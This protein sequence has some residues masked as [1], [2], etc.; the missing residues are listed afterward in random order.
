MKLNSV[1][2][3]GLTARAIASPVS[4]FQIHGR[5]SP[6]GGHIKGR[7]VARSAV[8]SASIALK[9]KNVKEAEDLVLEISDPDSP[10]YGQHL[11]SEEIVDLFAPDKEDID[12]VKAWLVA[13]GVSAGS[14]QLS[15]S[16]GWM[17]F[18]TT[19]GQL[20][21]MLHTQYHQYSARD[22]STIAIGADTYSL[23][24]DISPLVEF[25]HPATNLAG[26][27]RRNK[28]TK[29]KAL[30]PFTDSIDPDSLTTCDVHVTPKCIAAMY[31]IPKAR[32]AQ[33]GNELAIFSEADDKYAQE[34][35]DQ[36]FASMNTGIPKGTGPI[37][38]NI[39]GGHAPAAPG[40]AGDE[41]SIDFEVAIPIIYPQK[42]SLF[43]MG[44]D[45]PGDTY[46]QFL[47]LFSGS[48]CQRNNGTGEMAG[49]A[50]PCEKF[51]R[52]NVLSVSWG[53]IETPEP[54]QV[55]LN[56]RQCTEWMKFALAG[57]TVFSASGDDGV[58]Q[59]R[60]WGP[61]MDIFGNDQLSAC[62]YITAVGSTYLPKGAKIGDPEVATTSFSSGG[63]FS[64]VY[65]RPA[66]QEKAVATYL[67]HYVPN[68]RSFNTTDGK[69]PTAPGQG[70]YNR[71]GR[72]YPDISAVGDNG[73]IIQNGKTVVGGGTSMSAPIVASMFNRI[74]EE[75]ISMGKKPLGFIN[76]ALYKAQ[77]EGVFTDVVVGDQGQHAQA[78]G[79]HKGFVASKGWDPVTGLGTPRYGP[80]LEYFKNL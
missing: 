24:E 2:A 75:R 41:S 59:H 40:T 71:G 58:D 47:Q 19:A 50:P 25:L 11:T 46:D 18:N 77:S 6:A 13:S 42:T 61:D 76:P 63:G 8:I 68:Y 49:D 62:P 66:W 48:G 72:A 73:V 32:L 23:P 55:A 79:T 36:L 4:S 60:C 5:R 56:K 39:N 9:Q 52:P 17:Y 35:L 70:I 22:A 26:L 27:H 29:L 45:V 12:H 43:Q 33:P 31:G 10:K 64:F 7:A 69:I 20:G 74:N 15:G 37:I 80:M 30:S 65:P 3:C 44:D 57:A 1:I 16:R 14:I 51:R 78:C 53:T 67:E 21:D 54:D 28:S 34:D 38:H